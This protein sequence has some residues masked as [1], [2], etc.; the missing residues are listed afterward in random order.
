[1]SRRN[2]N[3]SGDVSNLSAVPL[4][5]LRV[6]FTKAKTKRIAWSALLQKV[7]RIINAPRKDKHPINN[8]M[9]T[10]ILDWFRDLHVTT[11]IDLS[12]SQ[13][14]RI[15]S[16]WIMV[17]FADAFAASYKHSLDIFGSIKQYGPDYAS[18]D[19]RKKQKINTMLCAHLRKYFWP[20]QHKDRMVYLRFK[21]AVYQYMNQPRFHAIFHDT[22]N[23]M[24]IIRKQLTD[25]GDLVNCAKLDRGIYAFRKIDFTPL[26]KSP[27]LE[28]DYVQDE[29]ESPEISDE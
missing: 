10:W 24:K 26:Q 6:A 15:L 11:F 4:Q 1:M 8:P 17:S 19:K 20:G 16:K 14:G 29:E 21:K 28:T 25:G 22:I 7:I 5:T 12:K 18:L 27:V 2:I 3:I 23:T 13:Q 9:W